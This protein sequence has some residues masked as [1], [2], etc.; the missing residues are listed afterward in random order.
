MPVFSLTSYPP[1]ILSGCFA[2]LDTLTLVSCREL[3]QNLREIIDSDIT[4][5]YQ[6][7][8]FRSG[9]IDVP[10]VF[11]NMPA[12]ERLD[13]LR[14]FLREREGLI[15]NWATKAFILEQL[16]IGRASGVFYD[17]GTFIHATVNTRKFRC[18]QLCDDGRGLARQW[19]F[20]LQ[21]ERPMCYFVDAKQDLL[22]VADFR[23][24]GNEEQR[25]LHLL[26]LEDGLPNPQAA[27][28]RI[29]LSSEHSVL[30][31]GPPQM[32]V[33]GDFLGIF[34]PIGGLGIADVTVYN[35]RTGCVITTLGFDGNLACTFIDAN[36]ILICTIGSESSQMVLKVFRLSDGEVV[37][38]LPLPE[39]QN[40][41]PSYLSARFANGHSNTSHS[42]KPTRP[43]QTSRDT[44]IIVLAVEY[45]EWLHPDIDT[46]AFITVFR[47]SV[48]LDMI[49]QVG[50]GAINVDWGGWPQS[51]LTYQPGVLHM[52]VSVHGR[53]MLILNRLSNKVEIYDY[54]RL[55]LKDMSIFCGYPAVPWANPFLTIPPPNPIQDLFVDVDPIGSLVLLLDEDLLAIVRVDATV[56]VCR[57][58]VV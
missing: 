57:V 48:I 10:S 52:D 40:T 5:Q 54:S 11:K 44:S 26:S 19:S 51:I 53:R 32:E 43:F 15:R 31:A 18:S 55:S 14:L 50:H 25:F 58:P 37:L 22:V 38:I 17:S 30:Y 49:R 8:L 24:V 41:G 56:E 35:W 21:S 12:I 46:W 23:D 1:E 2:H 45:R 39:I 36:H 20:T 42:N 16:P 3:C 9:M 6:I 27:S 47:H 33:L 29:T 13:A 28:P 34:L 7:E 4:L